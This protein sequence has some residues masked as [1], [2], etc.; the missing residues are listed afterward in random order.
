MTLMNKS[1]VQKQEF[2][3][4]SNFGWTCPCCGKVWS[5]MIKTCPCQQNKK[6]SA[7]SSKWIKD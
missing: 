5:P 4:N 6:E 2:N 7:Q 3:T 1:E